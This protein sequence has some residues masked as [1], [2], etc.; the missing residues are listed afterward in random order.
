MAQRPAAA[1]AGDN[2]VFDIDRFERL[3]R[4]LTPLPYE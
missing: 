1:V 4:T 3:H 2:I